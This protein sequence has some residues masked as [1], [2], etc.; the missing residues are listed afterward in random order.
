MP[1]YTSIPRSP[2]P[3]NRKQPLREPRPTTGHILPNPQILHKISST[4]H[5][6]LLI[7]RNPLLSIPGS[8]RA[9]NDMSFGRKVCGAHGFYLSNDKGA[10]WE[11][12]ES[13]WVEERA[14]G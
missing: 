8:A 1:L 4:N 6:R 3:F 13:G 5:H 9:R 10:V 11:D 12:T 14:A 7:D 2:F